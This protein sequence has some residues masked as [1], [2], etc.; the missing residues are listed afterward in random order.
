MKNKK[1]L[2]ACFIASFLFMLSP[3]I[4]SA[5]SGTEAGDVRVKVYSKQGGDWFR[6]LTRHADSHGVLE[7]K[8]VVPG[9]Y[10][11]VIDDRDVESGQTLAAKIRM[12]D[13]DGK[14]IKEKT[15]VDVSVDLNGT[16]T[17]AAVYESDEK[18]WIKMAGLTSE[19]KYYLD[20]SEADGSSLSDKENCP[21][22]KVKTKISNNDWFTSL[23]KRADEN[24]MLT[25]KNVLPGKYKFSYK[26]GDRSVTEPFTLRIKMLDEKGKKLDE[27]T[28]VKLYAYVSK[29]R[30]PIGVLKTDSSG[31]LTIPGVMTDMKY[32]IDL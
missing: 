32:K 27:A 2:S 17:L 23:Y 5:I 3:L 1:I 14:R 7:L 29:V 31:W 30:T 9:W 21:R 13:R 16:K 19:T 25:I 28:N 10:K 12:R 4:A 22:I 18:G 8:N 11:M 6:V 20:I 15:N 24:K 26:S